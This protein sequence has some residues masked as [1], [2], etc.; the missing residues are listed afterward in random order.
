MYSSRVIALSPSL[1]GALFTMI[2][3]MP[4]FLPV[5]GPLGTAG[6]PIKASRAIEALVHATRLGRAGK[7]PGLPGPELATGDGG[8]APR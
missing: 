2:L 1:F 5:V 6:G 8:S 7:T 4:V 3:G